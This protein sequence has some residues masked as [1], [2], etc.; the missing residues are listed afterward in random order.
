MSLLV[1]GRMRTTRSSQEVWTQ[2]SDT[3]AVIHELGPLGCV[4]IHEGG[5]RS[6]L[7]LNITF[8]G[9]DLA[10]TPSLGFLGRQ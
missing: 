2:L 10:V 8:L 7:M 4:G 6:F 9:L 5:Q 1:I 3:R